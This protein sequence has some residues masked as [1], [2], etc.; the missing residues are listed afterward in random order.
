MR[1]HFG[2]ADGEILAAVDIYAVTVGVDSH[3]IYRSA[4]TSRYDD[5]EVAATIDCHIAN[6]D[7]LAGLQGNRLVASAYRTSLHLSCL[8]SIVFGESFAVNHSATRDRY[9]LLAISPYQGVMEISVPTVLILWESELLRLVISLHACRCSNDYSPCLNTEFDVAL[10]AYGTRQIATGRRI[11]RG[12][13]ALCSKISYVV[14]GH[15]LQCTND[16]KKCHT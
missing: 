13:I 1:I 2:I 6:K 7:I 10:H 5:G 8:F 14:V 12:T 11:K 3:V 16:S 4:L 15:H 9:I